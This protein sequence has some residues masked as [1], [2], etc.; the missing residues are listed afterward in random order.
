MVSYV[1][2]V[3]EEQLVRIWLVCSTL[4]YQMHVIG[5]VD[6]QAPLVGEPTHFWATTGQDA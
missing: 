3:R 6:M 5:H 2:Q 4:L 1:P